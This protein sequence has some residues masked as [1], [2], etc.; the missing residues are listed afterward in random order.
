M[1]VVLQE[2]GR[3]KEALASYD[4]ALRISPTF[5]NALYNKARLKAAQNKFNDALSLLEDAV[6]SDTNCKQRAKHAREFRTIRDNEKF[7]KLTT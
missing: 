5:A 1:G 6:A 2:I 7:I 3:E 4:K